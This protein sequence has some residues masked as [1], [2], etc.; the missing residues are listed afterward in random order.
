MTSCRRWVFAALLL[1]GL[2]FGRNYG[3]AVF[4]AATDQSKMERKGA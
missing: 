1:A 3:K 4:A 2:L